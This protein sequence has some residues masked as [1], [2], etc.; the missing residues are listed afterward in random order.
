MAA[1]SNHVLTSERSGVKVVTENFQ[2]FKTALHV[3]VNSTSHEL[4]EVVVSCLEPNTIKDLLLSIPSQKDTSVKDLDSSKLFGFINGLELPEVVEGNNSKGVYIRCIKQ[5]ISSLMQQMGKIWSGLILDRLTKCSAQ[6]AN[7]LLSGLEARANDSLEETVKQWLKDPPKRYGQ[8][9]SLIIQDQ[10]AI[11]PVLQ[12]VDWGVMGD[13]H[14]SADWDV[15]VQITIEEAAKFTGLEQAKT[16]FDLSGSG[17]QESLIARGGNVR[18]INVAL[19]VAENGCIVATSGGSVSTTNNIIYSTSKYYD[20]DYPVKKLLSVNITALLCYTLLWMAQKM[21]FLL[22]SLYLTKIP[23]DT[24]GRN[25]RQYLKE[26][27]VYGLSVRQLYCNPSARVDF[28][29]KW[30]IPNL[31]L[32]RKENIQAWQ[33]PQLKALCWKLCQCLAFAQDK[34]PHTRWDLHQTMEDLYGSQFQ[35]CCRQ[36]QVEVEINALGDGIVWFMNGG[37]DRSLSKV[38]IRSDNLPRIL[39]GKYHP[40]TL[41]FLLSKF[42]TLVQ[43]SMSDIRIHVE[44]QSVYYGLEVLGQQHDFEELVKS[45]RWWFMQ[46]L[47]I[48][49]Q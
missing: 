8:I 10:A 42:V 21:K 2:S 24:H 33:Y 18:P 46:Q 3:E 35:V 23:N 12:F 41:S 22:P 44:L 49:S 30:V 19:V 17:I 4:S 15:W 48:L 47:D 45:R 1:S 40:Q 39:T 28:A 9:L 6:I 43:D 13:P 26:E 32:M 37:N 5:N 31:T 25:Y 16:C 20:N 7:L 27:D 14:G 38:C 36:K 29:L 34:Y 11:L